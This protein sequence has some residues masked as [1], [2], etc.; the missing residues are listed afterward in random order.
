M[1][2][3]D[4]DGSVGLIDFWRGAESCDWMQGHPMQGAP[5]S[6]RAV[7]CPFQLHGDDVTFSARGVGLC[8]SISSPMCRE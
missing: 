5:D 2:I 6:L 4:R 8:M 3:R 7:T 1:C